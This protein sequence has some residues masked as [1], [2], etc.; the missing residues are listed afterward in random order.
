MSKIALKRLTYSDV[1]IIARHY[2][3]RTEAGQTT[4]QKSIALPRKTFI[5]RFFPEL[6]AAAVEQQALAQRQTPEGVRP[7]RPAF[8]FPMTVYGPGTTNPFDAATK[9]TKTQ[10]NWRLNGFFRDPGNEGGNWEERDRFS[11]MLPPDLALAEEFVPENNIAIIEFFGRR[12]PTGGRIAFVCAP[13][14][15]DG[16]LF[17]ELHRL[18]GQRKMVERDRETLRYAFDRVGLPAD[19]PLRQFLQEPEQGDTPGYEAE[20]AANGVAAA[21]RRARGTRGRRGVTAQQHADWRSAAELVGT[22][23]EEVAHYHLSRMDGVTDVVWAS[24]QEDFYSPYDLRANR[25]GVEMKIEVKSTAYG[26]EEP[27]NISIGELEEAARCEGPYEL[28][29]LYEVGAGR[30]TLRVC[31]DVQ[32]FARGVLDALQPVDRLGVSV[33]KL[34]FSPQLIEFGP[35]VEIRIPEPEDDEEDDDDDE[36]P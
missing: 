2:Y 30:G 29:R 36:L 11:G 24:V 8:V 25:G 31:P 4:A 21:R 34:S 13:L 7:R 35:P 15:G 23:G 19:H 6:P 10:R 20:A 16:A 28:W 26:F 14:P 12:V 5:D 3:G 9:V 17:A 33:D 1:T 32:V 18:L 27:I 22:R